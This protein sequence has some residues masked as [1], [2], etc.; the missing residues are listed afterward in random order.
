MLTIDMRK[1]IFVPTSFNPINSFITFI[2]GTMLKKLAGNLALGA[3][4]SEEALRR[5]LGLV[6]AQDN[7]N[8]FGYIN[9]SFNF[10]D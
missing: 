4:I 3:T 6:G 2:G 1:V 9:T 7:I 5:G 8:T 10:G